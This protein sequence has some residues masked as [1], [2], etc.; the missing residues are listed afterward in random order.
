MRSFCGY[1]LVLLLYL[2]FL[3][4]LLNM[5]NPFPIFRGL[6]RVLFRRRR[7]KLGN[8]SPIPTFQSASASSAALLRF[9]LRPHPQQTASSCPHSHRMGSL[10]PLSHP[11]PQASSS[12]RVASAA[13][14]A[15]L[16][17]PSYYLQSHWDHIPMTP[18]DLGAH[19]HSPAFPPPLPPPSQQLVTHPPAQSDLQVTHAA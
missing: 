8:T 16:H 17:T 10:H 14:T 15:S 9:L 4:L 1:F 18:A 2:R 11:Q 12:Y 6:R 19:H 13:A 3:I 5:P 7:R